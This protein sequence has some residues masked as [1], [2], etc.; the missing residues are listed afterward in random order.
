MHMT[1]RDED[2]S[3]FLIRRM[4]RSR[5]QRN[6]EMDVQHLARTMTLTVSQLGWLAESLLDETAS[7][8][9]ISSLWLETSAV[10]HIEQF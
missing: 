4:A 10:N 9:C 5:K 3:A 1:S 6:E 8:P 2:F 7:L